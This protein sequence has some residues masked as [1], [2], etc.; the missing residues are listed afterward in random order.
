MTRAAGRAPATGH[1]R[2]PMPIHLRVRDQARLTP[3]GA[4]LITEDGPVLSYAELM[5][6]VDLLAARLSWSAAPGT[7][8]ALLMRKRPAA[9]IAMLATLSAGLT[10]VPLAADWPAAR[11]RLVLADAAPGLIL[12]DPD[13][14]GAA[15]DLGGP[16]GWVLGALGEPLAGAGRGG[17][18]GDLPVP[19]TADD[20]AFILYTSGSTGTPKGVMISH[21]NAAF[22]TGWASREFPLGPGDRVAVHAPLHFDLP[23]YDVYVG[24]GHG[25]ALCLVPERCA[26]FPEATFRFLRDTG[27]TA[28]YAVPSALNALV[29]RSGLARD[30]LPGLRQVLYAGE[31]YHPAPL[32]RLAGALPGATIANLYGPVETNVVTRLVIEPG[33]LALPRIPL[34][35]PGPGTQVALLAEAGTVSGTGPA[36]GEI[37]VAGPGVTPGYLNQPALTEAATLRAGPGRYYRT[38]DYARRDEAG[39][40]HFLGRRDGLVKTRGFRVE[41]GEVEAAIAALPGVRE[42]AALARPDPAVTTRLHALVIPA[43]PDVTAAGLTGRCRRLLPGYMVPEIHLLPA[44]PRTNTGKIARAELGGWLD[45]ESGSARTERAGDAGVV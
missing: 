10:Y 5:R 6:Q 18:V 21:R 31:E 37:L 25:A 2:A 30:G 27:V 39:L 29:T 24:L 45:R 22:F 35:N 15:T 26:L 8:V 14:A 7:R 3:S 4:A 42:V 17:P 16:G 38:G 33:H 12:T 23:V 28:L 34:G 11:Q 19:V 32:S 43:G 41:L 13:L 36:E 40:L 1:G 9:V 20:L 44:L